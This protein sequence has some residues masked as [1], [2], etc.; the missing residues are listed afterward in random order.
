M[1]GADEGCNG[2]T[3]YVL[4]PEDNQGDSNQMKRLL[5]VMMG[6]A[7]LVATANVGFADEKK[8]DDHH[9]KDKDHKKKKDH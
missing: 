5:A 7:L 4:L 8:K 9:D 3:S 6:A 1:R 2:G